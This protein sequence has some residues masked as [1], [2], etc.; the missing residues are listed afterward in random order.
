MLFVFS[1]PIWWGFESVNERSGNWEYRLPTDYGPFA[2]SALA[3]LSFSTVLP[4]VFET[5]EL[6]RSFGLFRSTRRWLRIAPGRTVLL[7]IATG[8][9]AMIVASL[10]FPRQ[11]FPLIW[12]GLF[13]LLDPLNALLGGKS[14]TAQVA[15]G[16]WDTVWVLFAAGITCGLLW[17]G[18]NYWS[19]PKW[20]YFV[21]YA[22]W[23][24]LFEM[25]ILGYGAYLPFAL[26]L[27]AA[28]QS[29]CLLVF[30][31][32]DDLLTFDEPVR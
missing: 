26:E 27:Y 13:F 18:W 4:A 24:K 7:A 6:Y 19:S 28:Y 31:R 12:I 30:R 8:G 14:L 20:V 17:E 29:L 10:L 16:R 21:T 9:A 2:Y 32:P 1:A 3:T 22:G 11:A 5:A 23:L 25:P 15:T